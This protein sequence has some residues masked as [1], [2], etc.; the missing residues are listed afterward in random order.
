MRGIPGIAPTARRIVMAILMLWRRKDGDATLW[1][2]IPR[3][4]L[5]QLILRKHIW[6]PAPKSGELLGSRKMSSVGPFP[7]VDID[8]SA[9]Q[10]IIW[11]EKTQNFVCAPLDLSSCECFSFGFKAAESGRFGTSTVCVRNGNF[12][13]VT[14]GRLIIGHVCR[15]GWVT[16]TGDQ[17]LHQS[18]NKGA[19]V[20]SHT[21]V[22]GPGSTWIY[23]TL[24]DSRE[25]RLTSANTTQAL[26]ANMMLVGAGPLQALSVAKHFGNAMGGNDTPR[27]NA[28]LDGSG[29]LG[30][31]MWS[32]DD[33]T[34][35]AGT[36]NLTVMPH[37]QG[38]DTF[39][40]ELPYRPRRTILYAD[41]HY[42]AV[43]EETYTL[44][45]VLWRA[46]LV[47]YTISQSEVSAAPQAS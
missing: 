2:E 22:C 20:V 30:P 17:H 16:T 37:D 7:M 24:T 21:H 47:L 19:S 11:G 18:W 26:T 8:A 1:S 43:L 3:D 40:F 4:V 9:S 35:F 31:A 45:T 32:L 12:S 25:Y 27:P 15:E 38:E 39:D 42:I 14:D 23:Q 33:L 36:H 5:Y 10:M 46:T 29:N 13:I 34:Y 44:P 28:H 6:I 41:T